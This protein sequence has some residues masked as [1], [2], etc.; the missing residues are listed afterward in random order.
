MTVRT[1]YKMSGVDPV[2]RTRIGVNEPLSLL[3]K[4]LK[5]KYSNPLTP[6]HAPD[7]CRDGVRFSELLV[8]CFAVV[9]LCCCVELEAEDIRLVSGGREITRSNDDS[10]AAAAARNRIIAFTALT[11]PFDLL[12][13]V[14]HGMRA[15]RHIPTVSRYRRLD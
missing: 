1:F 5:T 12:M 11:A 4:Q 13:V 9:L 14:D 2:L 10:D 6:T 8:Y 7:Q 15:Y 3:I